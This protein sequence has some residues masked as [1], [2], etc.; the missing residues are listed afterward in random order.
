MATTGSSTASTATSSNDVIGN[1]LNSPLYSQALKTS[2]LTEYL[3]GLMSG[4]YDIEQARAQEVGDNLMRMQAQREGIRNV[5]SD[6]AARG[7]RTP[8]M[9]TRGFAPIQAST[10][11]QREAAQ[12]NIMGMENRL[13]S[14]YGRNTGQANFMSQPAGFGT[15]GAAARQ[16][17]LSNLLQLPQNWGLTQVAKPSAAPTSGVI[18]R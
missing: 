14:M 5:A 4:T 18:S 8:N 11:R 16:Q 10:A 7:M 1:I 15:V 17:A 12:Q 13:E 9:V 6:Y 3:P 2:Y